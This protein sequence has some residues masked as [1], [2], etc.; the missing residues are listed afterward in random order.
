MTATAA[1]LESLNDLPI[2]IE[3]TSDLPTLLVSPDRLPDLARR[4]REGFSYNFLTDVTAVDFLGRDP[5]FEVVYHLYSTERHD[6]VRLKVPLPAHDVSVES[7]TP[8]WPAAN[9]YEREVFDL[10]GIRFEHHPDLKRILMPQKW[11]GH[12][13]RKDYPLGGEAVLFTHNIG[14]IEPQEIPWDQLEEEGEVD[15]S[16]SEIPAPEFL[17][18]P[19]SIPSGPFRLDI[20]MGPQ[21]PGTHGLLRLVLEIEGE[22]VTGAEPHIGY[23]HTG[24]EKS[25]E[26]LPYYQALTMTDRADYLS[27]LN[28]NLAYCMAVEKLL[29]LEVPVRAQYA[30]VILNELERLSS[31]LVWLAAHSIDLGMMSV[32]FYCFNAREKILDVKEL[33]SGVRMMTSYITIGGLRQDLPRGFEEAVRS[34]LREFPVAVEELDQ[35]LT[36]NP[37]WGERSKGVGLLSPEEALRWS[38]TGPN[39]R[40]SGVNLDLR[41]SRPYSCYDHFEF[42]V[43]LGRAG[44][45]YDR[46]LV[47]MEEMRQSLRIIQQ[48]L[49]RL[50]GGPWRTEDRKISL[51]PREELR[52]SME[53][54]IHHFMLISKS[55][56]VPPGEAYA[57]VEGPRGELGYYIVGDGGNKPCRVK[58]RDPS[59]AHAQALPIMIRGGLLADVVAVI[60]SVDPVLGGIDR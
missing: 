32:F 55:F 39:L 22:R 2:R 57:A 3:L 28:N 58:I 54:V 34:V 44:D 27:S 21:H 26:D 31:H 17:K 25:M 10:F 45:V 23:L 37:I 43:P 48:A 49:D 9:W 59:F 15:L 11:R 42:D 19:G 24:I 52:R 20:N 41:K 53:A 50:P 18:D 6:R 14:K 36:D 35:L 40:A 16:P 47:R 4:L 60:G 7:V 30:R 13:L 46:Y 12:P 51:P 38:V 29:G 8:I 56:S 33:C 1:L 5:R